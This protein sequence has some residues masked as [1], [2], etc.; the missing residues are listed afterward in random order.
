MTHSL[1]IDDAVEAL[2]T[3]AVIA[4]PTEAVWGLGCD[5]FSEPAV[6]HLLAIK[7]RAPEKGLILIG[8]DLEQ[9][10]GIVDW[11]QLS[12]VQRDAVTANWP[13]PYT[14]LVPTTA[15]VPAWISG[16]YD[17]VAIRVSAHPVVVELCRAYGGP[18]VSTSANRS[19]E[20]AAFRRDELDPAVIE[21]VYGVCE[22]ETSGLTAPSTIRDAR[23]GATL[24]I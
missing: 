10:D 1:S 9:F 23:S 15:R 13:G 14:W 4:Y 11:S 5:P 12:N 3:G 8:S 24:R 16:V 17:T 18:I 20:P 7:Q 2:R 22:G 19:G 21:Q 6:T